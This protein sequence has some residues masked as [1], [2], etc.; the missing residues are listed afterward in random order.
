MAV[1]GHDVS[2]EFQSCRPDRPRVTR[3]ECNFG[4]WEI[5]SR[6][7]DAQLRDYVIGYVGL[8]STM[9]V[10]RERH[11][12]S[13]E[14]ALVVNLGTEHDVIGSRGQG[15][16]LKF[17]SVAAMGVHD[18]P[19]VTRSAGDKHVLVVRL[20]PPG[21]R[22]LF[23]VEMDQLLNRWVDLDEIDGVLA[24][25]IEG[26]VHEQRGWN[27]LFDLMDSVLAERFVATRISAPGILWAWRELRRS[28]GL[29]SIDSL[30]GHLDWSHKRLLAGF[31]EHVGVLPKATANT[32]RFNRILRVPRTGYRIN[33]A[34]IAQDCG[35]YDQAH[36]IR[37]FKSFAG[38]TMK[39]LQSLV[40]GFT[41]FDRPPPA[42]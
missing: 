25:R 17:R 12:P 32:V 24:R 11:L 40:A 8:R 14:A 27:D 16:T 35:Y 5:A 7:P 3:Q 18:R 23:D 6:G 2:V 39:E 33:W 10:T 1:R 30:A 37:E 34:G 22:L 26:R 15:G 42:G 41:L 28:G 20:T 9:R 36:M 4:C 29:T 38:G 31:R 13:G 19:F 21:A